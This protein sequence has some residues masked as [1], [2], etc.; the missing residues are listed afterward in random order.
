MPKSMLEDLSEILVTEE[1]LHQRVDAMG[2]AMTQ[3]Y[4]DIGV[5]ELDIICITNGSILFCADLM[6]RLDVYTRLECVRVSSYRNDMKPVSEPE[7]LAKIRLNLEGRHVLLL[8]DILDTAQTLT[9]LSQVIQA[10]KPASLKS[11]V[12]LSKP[13]RR[14]VPYEADWIGFEIPDQF[15]VG[16]GLDFAERYR[17]LPCIGVLKPELQ[18][19]PEAVVASVS[20][21]E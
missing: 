8:D 4:K 2:A 16:Y 13:A 10:Q 6:R 11:A 5:N 12:L 21:A 7:I 20:T 14:Q 17:N 9:R 3:H 19:A 18:K 1:L 15:V